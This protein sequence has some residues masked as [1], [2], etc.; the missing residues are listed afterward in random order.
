MTRQQ[1]PSVPAAE[2]AIPSA[3]TDG[4]H[5]RSEIAPI[6]ARLLILQQRTEQAVNAGQWG[7]MS[8]L[9]GLLRRVLSDLSPYRAQ[10]TE[11]QKMLL[12]RFAA[13]Y[14]EHFRL[15]SEQAG[16]LEQQLG[17]LR[18]QHQGSLAYDWISQLE[19]QA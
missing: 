14:R 13:Q 15:V 7:W 10:L 6:F 18:Q 19:E 12:N 16:R 2:A 4:P 1:D 11:Q 5:E 9:D 17:Q 8:E 3:A